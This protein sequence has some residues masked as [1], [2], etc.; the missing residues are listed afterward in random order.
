MTLTGMKASP[1]RH[2]NWHHEKVLPPQPESQLFLG[3]RTPSK[4]SGSARMAPSKTHIGIMALRGSSTRWLRR[5]QPAQPPALP[6]SALVPIASTSFGLAPREPFATRTGRTAA[7]LGQF[8]TSPL[9]WPQ[10]AQLQRSTAG[11]R[12]RP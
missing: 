3:D 9:E 7:E 2:L 5:A 6:P 12:P 4:S 11:A 8:R 10:T 1:G